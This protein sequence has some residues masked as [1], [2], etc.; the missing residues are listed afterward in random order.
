MIDP[1]DKKDDER[2]IA[3]PKPTEADQ[4]LKNQPEYTDQEPNT[5]NKEISDT[6][7]DNNLSSRQS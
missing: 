1:K 6:G 5:Y 3:Y 4:Q 2:P 7:D